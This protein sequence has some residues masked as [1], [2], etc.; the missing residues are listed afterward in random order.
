MFWNYYSSSHS[1]RGR[2]KLPAYGALVGWKSN[3]G[4]I[5][6]AVGGSNVATTQGWDGDG[7]R[8]A[9]KNLASST[10][11]G[12]PNYYGWVVPRY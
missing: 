5:A 6:V 7:L 8:I 4:H 3:P 11:F 1:E 2:N 9:R 10:S 12:G